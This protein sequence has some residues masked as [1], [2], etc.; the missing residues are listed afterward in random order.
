MHAQRP[1]QAGQ[2]GGWGCVAG[3]AEDGVR[4]TAPATAVPGWVGHTRAD[5]PAAG[6]GY[7]GGWQFVRVQTD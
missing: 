1:S 6:I 5:V 2:L 7:L 3:G 4:Q